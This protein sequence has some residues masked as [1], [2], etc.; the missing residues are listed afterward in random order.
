MRE[1]SRKVKIAQPSV[2]AHLKALEKQGLI[3][4]EKNGLYPTYRANRENQEFKTLKQTNTMLNLNKTGLMD[5]ISNNCLPNSIVLF[6]SASK[7]EDIEESDIDLF[8]QSKEKK[9]DLERFEKQ[10]NRKISLFFQEDINKLSKELRN[11]IINGIILKGYL[12]VF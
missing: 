10:L 2:I 7:G 4:R 8:V 5:Y 9:L 1:I 6:G 11:N 3:E 12:K